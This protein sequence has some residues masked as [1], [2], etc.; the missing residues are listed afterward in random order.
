MVADFDLGLGVD[1]EH[2]VHTRPKFD[3]SHPLAAGHVIARLLN[4]NDSPRQQTGNLLED[5]RVSLAADGNDVLF[6]LFRGDR[7]HSVAELSGLVI[8]VGN[9]SGD[10]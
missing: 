7:S 10:R 5:D 9:N 3:E 1:W 6:V 8:N 4:E 2:H